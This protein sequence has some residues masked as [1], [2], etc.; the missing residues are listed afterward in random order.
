LGGDTNEA[1][2]P[3]SV[4][5]LTRI[6]AIAAG[7]ASDVALDSA[8]HVWTWSDGVNGVLGD[9]GTGDHVTDAVEVPGLPTIVAIGEADDTDVAIDASGTSGAGAGTKVV[10]CAPGIRRNTRA[11]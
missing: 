7:N 9:G 11:R 2:S 1:D 5:D 8:G 10:S 3:I 4:A 6:T